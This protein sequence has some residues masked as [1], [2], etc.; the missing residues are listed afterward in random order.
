MRYVKLNYLHIY[1]N[2]A[3]KP[4]AIKLN[5]SRLQY[6]EHTFL[7]HYHDDN[8]NNKQMNPNNFQINISI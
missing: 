4:D 3:D 6:Q 7:A 1:T 2:I 8:N 5:Q